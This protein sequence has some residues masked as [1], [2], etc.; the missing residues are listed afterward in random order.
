M[1]K[2]KTSIKI[3]ENENK[4]FAGKHQQDERHN[5]VVLHIV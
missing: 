4:L 3:M 1:A 2:Q 5:F